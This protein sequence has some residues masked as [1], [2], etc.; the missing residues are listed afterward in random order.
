[1][2]PNDISVVLSANKYD[3]PVI[4]VTIREGGDNGSKPLFRKS[5]YTVEGMLCKLRAS[6]ST[7]SKFIQRESGYVSRLA[8]EQDSYDDVIE[9]LLCLQ[10]MIDQCGKP[11]HASSFSTHWKV[12]LP[13]CLGRDCRQEVKRYLL[14]E[15]V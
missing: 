3:D 10:F 14:G 1:M 12:S 2:Y 4:T 8:G 6:R 15:L 5:A 7:L 13:L 11:F 9:R